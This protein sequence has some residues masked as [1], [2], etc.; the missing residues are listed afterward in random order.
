MPGM[1]ALILAMYSSRTPP[2]WPVFLLAPLV[3]LL[4]TGILGRVSG[5]MR[6]ARRFRFTG[7]SYTGSTAFPCSARVGALNYNNCL[8]FGSGMDG[9]YLRMVLFFR[10]A[11]PTLLIPWQEISVSRRKFMWVEYVVLTCGSEEQVR[12]AI[13]IS[14]ALRL[15]ALSGGAWPV[16]SVG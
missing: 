2:P 1:I 5:W 6:L 10:W 7:F 16:E 14:L 3:F 9:L 11:H 12:I 8:T 15:Q 13:S 4:V